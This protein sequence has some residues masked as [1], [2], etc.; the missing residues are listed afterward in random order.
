MEFIMSDLYHREHPVDMTVAEARA[1]V[2]RLRQAEVERSRSKPP[3]VPMYEL[4]NCPFDDMPADFGTRPNEQ[5]KW[6]IHCNHCTAYVVADT[7]EAVISKWNNR[8]HLE[9][10]ETENS[11]LAA[12]ACIYPNGEGLFGDEHGNSFCSVERERVRLDQ[13]ETDLMAEINAARYPAPDCVTIAAPPE[14]AERALMIELATE[15]ALAAGYAPHC[16][17]TWEQEATVIIPTIA[18]HVAASHAQNN[19]APTKDWLMIEIAYC[20]HID[21][22]VSEMAGRIYA[23]FTKGAPVDN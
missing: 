20:Q 6:S 11:Q 21:M 2:Q 12:G 23:A 1:E 9:R 4:Q 15:M 7:R 3:I 18:K 8:P 22:P 5:T 17:P 13:R 14:L 10:L 19:T 16:W